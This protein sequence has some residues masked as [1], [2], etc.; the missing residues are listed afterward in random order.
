MVLIRNAR[1]GFHKD[2]ADVKDGWV[3]MCT[4]GDFEGGEMLIPELEGTVE[5]LKGG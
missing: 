1:V 2:T 5:I 4:C 3:V